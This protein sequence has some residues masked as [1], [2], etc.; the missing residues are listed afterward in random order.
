M[1]PEARRRQ[2][3]VAADGKVLHLRVDP[4]TA[5]RTRY[6]NDAAMKS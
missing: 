3:I 1:K 4:S 5:M 2:A 6:D